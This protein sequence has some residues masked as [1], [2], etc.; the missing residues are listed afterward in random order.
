MAAHVGPTVAVSRRNGWNA[1]I[2]VIFLTVWRFPDLASRSPCDRAAVSEAEMRRLAKCPGGRGVD[3]DGPVAAALSA[4]FR[5]SFCAPQPA[6][7]FQ[8]AVLWRVLQRHRP[9]P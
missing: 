2:V 3:R 4:L 1:A 7:A 5:G 9:T 8:A 6:H